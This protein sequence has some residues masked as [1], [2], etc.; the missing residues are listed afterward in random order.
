MTIEELPD[1][2]QLPPDE[3][4]LLISVLWQSL[5]NYD[6][7]LTD[8]DAGIIDERLHRDLSNPEGAMS[9][10]EFYRRLDSLV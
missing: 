9:K 10:E 4:L 1:L 7:P 2:T 5:R 6:A 8:D 3:R